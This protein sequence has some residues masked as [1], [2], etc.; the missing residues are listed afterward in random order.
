MNS[1]A[2]P[3]EPP[4]AA[5]GGLGA[6]VRREEDPYRALDDLMA[7][8]EALCPVWPPRDAF[9]SGARMLL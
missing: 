3:A 1:F 7:V 2:K 8:V 9:T 5:E 4:F 6:S